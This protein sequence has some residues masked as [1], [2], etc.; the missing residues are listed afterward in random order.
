MSQYTP[1]F[2]HNAPPV[3]RFAAVPS[4]DEANP[5]LPESQW[6]EHDDFA[7]VWPQIESQQNNNCTDASLA[8]LAHALFKFAGVENVPRFSWSFG[9]SH[10]NG[11]QDQGAYCRELAKDFRDGP[12]RVPVEMW[13]DSRIVANSWPPE[14][15]A[16]A[17][18]WR[19]LEVYQCLDWQQIG[20][21]LTRRFM[22]YHGFVL[23]NAFQS[24]GASGRVP[25]WDG[26]MANGHAMASRGL[27]KVFGD[28]RT[29]TPN[30]WGL[31]FG[32]KGVGFWPKSYFWAQ[33]R[34][35]VNLE[36]FAV[37]APRRVDPL[38]KAEG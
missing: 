26:R 7:Q 5:T 24:T 31:G 19:A 21:A 35:F 33:N 32:D 36:A 2:G 38:P 8:G 10:H 15:L 9:Y 22:V 28:W 34:G 13:P 6:E 16:E 4:W 18:R 27:T 12:G 25:E 3:L 30:T 20:S 29:I 23:G 14:V 11:G 37:R 17:D 1:R